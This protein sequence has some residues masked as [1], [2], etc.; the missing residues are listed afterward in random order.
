MLSQKRVILLLGGG[1]IMIIASF[2]LAPVLRFGIFPDWSVIYD[3]PDLSAIF[4]YLLS[5][6]IFDF[7]NPE[8]RFYTVGYI[9]RFLMALVAA[10]LFV[11][12]LF[13]VFN[14]RPYATVIFFLNTLLIFSFCL[15][16][17]FLLYEEK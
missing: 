1:V 13:Y 2:Y 11:A 5:F 3:L 9:L 15:G 14:V 16:W 10:D 6:Y 7:Y 8:E 12:T 17:R 4:V